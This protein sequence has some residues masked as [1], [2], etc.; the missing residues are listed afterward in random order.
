MEVN[1]PN[2]ISDYAVACSDILWFGVDR[3]GYVILS[4]SLEGDIPR[5]VKENY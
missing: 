3:N 1:F 2:F 5:F 4:N